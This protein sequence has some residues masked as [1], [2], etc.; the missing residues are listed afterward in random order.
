MDEG[1]ASLASDVGAIVAVVVIAS[2]IADVIVDVIAGVAGVAAVP[3]AMTGT[4]DVGTSGVGV[5]A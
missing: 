1:V 4:V 3:L 2:V 5:A